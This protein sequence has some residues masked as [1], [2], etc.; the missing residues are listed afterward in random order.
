MPRHPDIYLSIPEA[1]KRT[2][3]LGLRACIRACIAIISPPA[4]FRGPEALLKPCGR[5]VPLRRALRAPACCVLVR[6]VEGIQLKVLC[7]I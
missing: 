1:L 4:T 3:L 7:R 5:L 6:V 2:L